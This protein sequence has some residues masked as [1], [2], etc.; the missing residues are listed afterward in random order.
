MCDYVSKLVYVKIIK[1][2]KGERQRVWEVKMG[3]V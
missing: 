2:Q 3:C 1:K